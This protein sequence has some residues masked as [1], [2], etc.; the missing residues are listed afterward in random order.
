VQTATSEAEI[1]T[2]AVTLHE[3]VRFVEAA[4][5]QRLA[6]TEVYHPKQGPQRS[7][8]AFLLLHGF[9]QNRK[10]FTLGPMPEVL[11][12]RGAQVFLGEL[13]G[14]GDSRVDHSHSWNLKTHLDLDCPALI[15]AVRSETGVARVHLIGH[16]MGGLLGCALLAR[17]VPLASHTAAATPML[18][19]SARPL[20]RLAS[21]LV[22]PLATIAPKP[23]RVPMHH[24]LRALARPLSKP[25]ARGPLRLLQRVTRLANPE[26]AP[27][28]ALGA[29]LASADPESPAVMEELARNAVLLRPR[30]AGVDLVQAVHQ[31]PL[32]VAAVVGTDDIFA[33][34]A[35]VA[36]LEDD[37]QAGPR[38]IVEIPGG[39]HVDAIMGH[40]VPETVASLWDFLVASA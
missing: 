4:D 13:R 3:H 33:P 38:R 10:G 21:F 22:G 28:Q 31:S 39:T 7:D 2:G 12:E 5:G 32:P 19:G 20:I 14:H 35:A 11:L 18:L 6:L 30:F 1:L 26:S 29:I 17:E 34:R 9:A 36:P 25:E 16:S 8:V 24:F 40:H 23:H 15:D 37:D 27:P